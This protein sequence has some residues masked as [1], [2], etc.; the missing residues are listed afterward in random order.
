[1]S[2]SQTVAQHLPYLRRYA[3]ALAGDQA[4]GDAY[5]AATL[6]ALIAD[7]STLDA[8]SSTRVGLY[9]L[10]TKIWNSVGLNAKSGPIE[11]NLPVEK[12]L[13]QITPKP[14][15]AF[16]LVA[17]EGLSE[18]DAAKVLDVDVPALRKLVEDSGRELAAEIAT[19]VLIIEDETFIALDLEGLVESLGHRVL[20]V[21]RTHTEAVAL[22]KAKRPGLILADIQLADGSSG[23]DAVNEMLRTFE[24]PVIFITAYPE[25]FLTGERPEPAFLIAKPF[26]PS[27]V[28]AV[29]SQALFFERKAKR[30]DRRATA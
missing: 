10:F 22:A 25:R 21:A 16:L 17:L 28:S 5:V 11:A 6:E 30:R 12:R 4:S 26:Q 13:A 24:V 27:T 1:L 19:D 18:D 23:L 2:T 29:L 8:G 3:R 15:Q 7:P 14:R 9:K 20:G